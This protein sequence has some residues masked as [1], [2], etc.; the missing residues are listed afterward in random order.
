MPDGGVDSM[1]RNESG[2]LVA[3]ACSR[4]NDAA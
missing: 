3:T 2:V 4:L 1:K